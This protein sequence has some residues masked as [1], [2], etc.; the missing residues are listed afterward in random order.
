MN[1]LPRTRTWILLACF[2]ALLATFTGAGSTAAA[3]PCQASAT[4]VYGP[5]GTAL[6]TPL[7]IEISCDQSTQV[8]VRTPGDQIT[9]HYVGAQAP[10]LLANKRAYLCHSHEANVEITSESLGWSESVPITGLRFVPQCD[11]MLKQGSTWVRWTGP[12]FGLHEAFA[13]PALGWVDWARGPDGTVPGLVAWSLVPGESPPIKGWGDIVPQGLRGLTQLVPGRS[14]L[15]LSNAERAWTFPRPLS[16]RSVL[17]TAQVVSFYG[18]PGVPA[19]GVLGHAS[20]A[21]IADEIARWADR[22]DALNGPREV[23]PAFHLITGVAQEFPTA[24]GTWL[25]RLSG[26]RIATF[27]ETAR[28]RGML[29]FL[30]TQVGWSDPL[31]EVQL[32]EPFLREP[33]VHMAIDP[34]FAT[35]SRG[36]RPGLVIGG[37]EAQDIN[38]VQHY[39]ATLANEEGIPPKILMVHQFAAHMIANRADVEDV[40]GV[41]L[42]IDMDGFGSA[43]LKLRHYDWYSLTAP[44]ERPA[45]KLFFDQDTPVMTPEQVQALDRTPDL[46]IYQ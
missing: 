23:V 25:Y 13:G 22:Y 4:A 36:V 3:G 18:H 9:R 38:S 16:Q 5:A 29:L 44:S 43:A 15:L 35:R 2:G 33:F 20:P 39:L 19:M 40:D 14:Y 10:R 37:I 32:L 8:T 45:L 11:L 26:E 12:Q 31:R 34:E 27:V 24:D 21:D 7:A 6:S 17:D 28:E 1:K 46:I 30:D 41:E 42:S